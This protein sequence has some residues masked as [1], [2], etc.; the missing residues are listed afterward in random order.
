MNKTFA[1]KICHLYALGNLTQ[2]PKAIKGSLL[3]QIWKFTTTQGIYAIKIVNLALDSN[4]TQIYKKFL[5][6]E[7]VAQ[8]VASHNIPA[9]TALQVDRSP[10]CEI[11]KTFVLVFPWITGNTLAASAATSDQAR[12]IGSWLAKIHALKITVPELREMEY[13][14]LKN[15]D[16]APL[17]AKIDNACFTISFDKK[18]LLTELESWKQQYLAVETQIEN[19]AIVSHGDL[20]QTNVIWQDHEHPVL[21]DW[22]YANYL[23]P[24]IEAIDV[25][26][27]WSGITTGKIDKNTFNAV[28]SGYFSAGGSI[29]L[30]A[31]TLLDGFLKSP[32]NWLIFNMQRAIGKYI[33]TQKDTELGK[34]EVYKTLRALYGLEKMRAILEKLINRFKNENPTNIFHC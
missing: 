23:N 22:E 18:T 4:K 3:N 5:L 7:K 32:L 27:N 33:R 10:I 9:L 6:S 31:S 30:P 25:A 28:L 2:Q 15:V 14:P 34:H 19:T 1:Q 17:L 20:H 16:F 26:L 21:L 11:D 29:S 24:E 12:Q 13:N 8:I